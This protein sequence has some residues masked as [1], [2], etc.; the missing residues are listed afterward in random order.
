MP[1]IIRY[2]VGERI[3]LSRKMIELGW[4]AEGLVEAIDRNETFPYLIRFDDGTCLRVA[5]AQIAWCS[6]LGPNS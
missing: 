3:R 6:Q 5:D 2:T 4:Q 1:Q